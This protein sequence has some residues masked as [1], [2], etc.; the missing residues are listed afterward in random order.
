MVTGVNANG[1]D[2]YKPSA[3]FVTS[4]CTLKLTNFGVETNSA[5]GATGFCGN[6]AFDLPLSGL[7]SAGQTVNLTSIKYV[8]GSEGEFIDN[9]LGTTTIFYYTDTT[10]KAAAGSV[11]YANVS[12]TPVT[13][14][15]ITYASGG[16]LNATVSDLTN[17]FNPLGKSNNVKFTSNVASDKT[18]S[19]TSS[20]VSATMSLK[21]CNVASATVT[22]TPANI[23]GDGTGKTSAKDYTSGI[24]VYTGSIDPSID[25][26]G[27]TTQG[28]IKA[29]GSAWVSANKLGATDLQLLNGGIEYPTQNFTGYNGANTDRDYSALGSG[30]KVYYVKLPFAR[31]TQQ[32]TLTITGSGL[33]NANLK[34]VCVANSL[35][36]LDDRDALKTLAQGGVNDG[37][38]EGTTTRVI[39]LSYLG[40]GETI[41]TA[42]AYA[43]IVMSGTGAVIKTIKL[44]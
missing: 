34:S 43:K 15:G 20:A 21:T 8:N 36:V 22:A 2:A 32:L 42:G 12:F 11:T 38:N 23:N 18:V 7:A 1:S 5:S 30:D 14:S 27:S 9:S 40:V 44:A 29:D 25:E 24:I 4:D 31:S 39:N 3:N 10:T 37:D 6:I 13:K 17:L 35:S 33:T 26:N 41:N 28:R 19:T 16:T